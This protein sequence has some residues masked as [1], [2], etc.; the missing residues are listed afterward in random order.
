MRKRILTATGA[1]ASLSALALGGS[2]IASAQSSSAPASHAAKVHHTAEKTTGPDTDNVQS[3][4]Q[5]TPDTRATVNATKAPSTGSGT[6]T[7]TENGSESSTASDG[8]GGHQDPAGA[9]VD[10]QFQGQE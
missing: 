7:A 10:H 8:P 9:N 1:I 4:D 2:A 5:T 6:E 3:G